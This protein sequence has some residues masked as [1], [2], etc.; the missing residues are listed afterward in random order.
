MKKDIKTSAGL[1]F[2]DS[3]LYR[4][5]QDTGPSWLC[6]VAV[7][8]IWSFIRLH[9]ASQSQGGLKTAFNVRWASLHY[10]VKLTRQLAKSGTLFPTQRQDYR[11]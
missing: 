1:F 9:F 6:V 5:I 11:L 3:F 4:Y 2:T 8:P 7:R 10:N